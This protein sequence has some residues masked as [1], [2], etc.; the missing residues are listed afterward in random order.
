MEEVIQVWQGGQGVALHEHTPSVGGPVGLQHL[1]HRSAL[2]LQ[3]AGGAEEEIEGDGGDSGQPGGQWRVLHE[4]TLPGGGTVALEAT[5]FRAALLLQ[6]AGGAEEE[7]EAGQVR[8]GGQ[9]GA[10][11]EH[12][13]P[14]GAKEEFEGVEG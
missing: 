12:A 11:H 3:V 8:P 10:L 6:V 2:L 13:L 1:Q 9:R 5:H 7:L 4:H 14:G